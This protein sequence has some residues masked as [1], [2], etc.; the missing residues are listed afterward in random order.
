MAII[1][2][3]LLECE[4]PTNTPAD[5][6][7]IIRATAVWVYNLLLICTNFFFLFIPPGLDR[8][9]CSRDVLELAV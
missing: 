8:V 5:T 6:E 2:S 4:L 1:P 9:S 7:Q 3:P